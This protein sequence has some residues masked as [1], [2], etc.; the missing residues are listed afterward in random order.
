MKK[1]FFFGGGKLLI[2]IIQELNKKIYYKK[3]EQVVILSNRHAKEK[4]YKKLSFK[5]FLTK[6]KIK[7]LVCENLNKS[8]ARKD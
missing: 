7:F 4:V 6:N 2:Q 1:I 8:L 5:N 3:F